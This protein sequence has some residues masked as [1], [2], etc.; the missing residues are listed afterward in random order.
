MQIMLY[1]LKPKK[2][3]RNVNKIKQQEYG[4]YLIVINVSELYSL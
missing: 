1:V 3:W 4:L 2:L